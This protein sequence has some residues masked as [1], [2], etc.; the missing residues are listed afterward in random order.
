MSRTCNTHTVF[1]T[2][3][4]FCAFLACHSVVSQAPRQWRRVEVQLPSAV[5][6]A[7]QEAKINFSKIEC[8]RT[9]MPRDERAQHCYTSALLRIV[10]GSACRRQKQ[11]ARKL[12]RLRH[13]TVGVDHHQ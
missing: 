11:S 7:L 4:T 5:T 6:L 1:H 9:F 10:L 13:R 3:A 12:R 2:T 8:K